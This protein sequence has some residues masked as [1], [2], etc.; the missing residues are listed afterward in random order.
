MDTKKIMEAL[1]A[2]VAFVRGQIGVYPHSRS[3][4][5]LLSVAGEA[6]AELDRMDAGRKVL[7]DN[8]YAWEWDELVE[9]GPSRGWHTMR[10]LFNPLNNPYR[11]RGPHNVRNLKPLYL[12]PAPSGPMLT[13]EK[14]HQIALRWVSEEDFEHG[15]TEQAA[16]D[17]RARLTEAAKQNER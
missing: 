3:I 10:E 16:A 5:R 14:A 12:T 8:P 7:T 11:N 17:L 2:S 1:E 9:D 13:V 6:L 15:Y 4:P